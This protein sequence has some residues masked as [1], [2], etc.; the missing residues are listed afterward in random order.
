M[1]R[2]EIAAR[3]EASRQRLRYV[4]NQVVVK[5]REG[6]ARAGQQRALMALRS[7][8]SV[9]DLKWAGPV[10]VVT[11]AGQSNPLILAQQL[12][13][14]PEVHYAE[15]NYL[16]RTTARPNDPG[17]SNRQW[18]FDAIDLPRAWDVSP[19]GK[20]SVVVAIVDT[21]M[22]TT[23]SSM[24][25][26]T[27]DG[28][29]FVNVSVPFAIS[30][31]ITASRFVS[32]FDF[33]FLESSTVLDMVGHGTHVGSTAAE[34]TNNSLFEAGIAYNAGIMPVKVCVSYWELQFTMSAR[35]IPGFTSPTE[36]GGCSNA[37][38]GA[39]LRYAADNG[40]K[41]INV[42]LGGPGEALT[43]RDA[44]AYAVGKGVFV[45]ISAG[46]SFEKGN[47]ADFP[48]KYAETMEG[49]MAVGAIG[50]S[51][52]HAY[53]SNT[54]SYIEIAAPGGDVRAGGS[55]GAIWQPTIRASDSDPDTII[56]PRFDRYAEAGF[57]G[58][59]MA[60]PHVAG[61]AALLMSQLGSAARPAIV[62]QILKATA[63]ACDDGS[64]DPAAARVGTF[65][66]NDTFGVGLI[67]PR[68]ALFGSGL[69]K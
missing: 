9:D 54:G 3:L 50:R 6:V 28:D 1:N 41:V 10:A 20:S 63:R 19:G 53:Y 23:N 44:L 22:T 62:E 57:Q 46:N 49:V 29:G 30:P 45:A 8:P 64:C 35:G 56:F 24:V 5:F 17:Y 42:S 69:R 18:N 66:R 36:E 26:R 34:D 40:A 33:A 55:A 27:W 52:R 51:M 67:Q 14:Q 7:R 61:V 25:F 65:G 48:A 39:G 38:I 58:T 31:D 11:D 16:Y 2:L 15:P 43:L 59:S 37:D 13:E 47:E 68:T 4:P 12:R 32:P 21:G 60:S